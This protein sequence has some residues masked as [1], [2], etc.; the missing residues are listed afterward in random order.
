M[1]SAVVDEVTKAQ[2]A[3]SPKPLKKWR[4]DY[5]SFGR[6]DIYEPVNRITEEFRPFLACRTFML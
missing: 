2:L 3:Y 1:L 6:I 5:R 4:V